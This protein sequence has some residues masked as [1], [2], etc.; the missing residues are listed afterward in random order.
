MNT[1]VNPED[2]HATLSE[3]GARA[4]ILEV[5]GRIVPDADPETISEDTPLRSELEMDSL[6]F[7]SFVEELS[8]RS[9]VRIEE[10]DY[11]D[12]ATLGR[13]AAFLAT[14]G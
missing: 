11:P 8:T 9:G 7:L 13:G 3:A 10:A 6:D 1:S 4:L 2:A 14:H 5:L 12:F